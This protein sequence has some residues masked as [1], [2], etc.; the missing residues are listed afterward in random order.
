VDDAE[1]GAEPPAPSR[2]R[3][4]A[5]IAGVALVLALLVLLARPGQS[6]DP[7]EDAADTPSTTSAPPTTRSA[8]PASTVPT[9]APPVLDGPVAGEPSGMTLFIGGDR[10][11]TAIDLDSGQVSQYG[12]MAHP[13]LVT[14][15]DLVLYQEDTGIVGWVPVEDPGRQALSWKRGRVAAGSGPG[16]LWILDPEVDEPHPAGVDVGFGRW[17]LFETATN[18]RVFR[19]PGDLYPDIESFIEAPPTV[20]GSFEAVRPGPWFSTRRDGVY[21]AIEDGYTRV[22]DGRVLANDEDVLVEQCSIE[23]VCNVAWYAVETGDP[24]D[25]VLPQVRPRV[26]R[27]VAGGAWLH[28]VGWAGTSELLELATGRRIEHDWA[29]ARPTVSPDG[30][31]LAHWTASSSG[32]GAEHTLII[33]DLATDGDLRPVAEIDSIEPGASTGLLF[34]QTSPVSVTDAG[35]G[36]ARSSGARS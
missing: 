24:V 31:W 5:V 9:T 20:G 8:R 26:A 29:E 19:M 16:L 36:D 4:T 35:G 34:V 32:S 33:S 27:L 22:A 7:S 15:G 1:P 28:S 10:P 13:V 14:G 2:P 12:L 30:R 3:L 6:D 11:L 17:E 18:R 21:R 25:R 23:G